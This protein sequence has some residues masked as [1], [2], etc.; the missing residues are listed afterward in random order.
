MF[1][2]DSSALSNKNDILSYKP[3]KTKE[4]NRK[5]LDLGRPNKP[6]KGG[7]DVCGVAPGGERPNYGD[8]R[9]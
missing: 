7:D 2:A 1:S 3:I 6:H 9:K 5:P 8:F 4:P